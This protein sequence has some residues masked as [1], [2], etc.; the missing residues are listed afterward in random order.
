[1]VK[2]FVV[3]VICLVTIVGVFGLNDRLNYEG[4]QTAVESVSASAS[5][6]VDDLE[7][8]Q[9]LSG[10]VQNFD[11]SADY[12]VGGV[13]QGDGSIMVVIDIQ[14]TGDDGFVETTSLSYTFRNEQDALRLI[15]TL[16]P[17]TWGQGSTIDDPFAP[18]DSTS[19]LK[20]IGLVLTVLMVVVLLIVN[21]LFDSVAVAMSLVDAC[22]YLIGF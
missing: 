15:D 11:P 10:I 18:D 22:F 19:L 7:Y 20:S 17:L 8:I 9:A 5:D 2:K 4:L 14:R 12:V 1:M 6:M 16:K 13:K 21:L 3:V